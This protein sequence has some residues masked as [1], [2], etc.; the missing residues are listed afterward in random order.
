MSTVIMEKR[1]K[2]E[3]TKK[4]KSVFG[5]MGCKRRQDYEHKY[6]LTNRVEQTTSK[7]KATTFRIIII[8]IFVPLFNFFF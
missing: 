8:I 4:K 1:G 6:P 5:R 7:V 3:F 2:K